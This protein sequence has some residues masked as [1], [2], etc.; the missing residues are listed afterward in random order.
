MLAFC[1][2]QT[3]E[4]QNK[5]LRR[6]AQDATGEAAA[7]AQKH[8]TLYELDLGLNHVMRKFSEPID[9]GANMLIS[10]PGEA[11]GPGGVLVC[12]ENFVI[13][14]NE[15]QPELRAVI[16]RRGDLP[17]DRGV[18]L[19][20]AAT[21]KQKSMFF[22]LA[23][24]EYGDIYKITLDYEGE[25]VSE[26]KIKY[27]DTIPPC[28]SICVLKTGFLFAGSEFGNHALYQFQAS[29]RPGL[30]IRLQAPT[31]LSGPS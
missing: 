20:A 16:P 7:E 11:D 21:H 28:T 14:K 9:N 13:W 31:S 30:M 3:L 17:P 2:F 10:V 29:G 24:S 23:Q 12:A 18:L 22:F 26:L 8:L 4:F 19:I 15:G 5:C 25:T 27:F 1:S 6:F